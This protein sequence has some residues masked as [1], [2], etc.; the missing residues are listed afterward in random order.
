MKT[1]VAVFLRNGKTNKVREDLREEPIVGKEA[2]DA[3]VVDVSLELQPEHHVLEVQ[4]THD[5]FQAIHIIAAR[6]SD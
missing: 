6:H 2:V 4:K 3:N 1:H 5:V